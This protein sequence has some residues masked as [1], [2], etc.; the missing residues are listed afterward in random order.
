MDA[1]PAML[2]IGSESPLYT[3]GYGECPVAP[4]ASYN[5]GTCHCEMKPFSDHQLLYMGIQGHLTKTRRVR[6]DQQVW[7]LRQILNDPKLQ[8]EFANT[9]TNRGIL[10][11]ISEDHTPSVATING[12]ICKELITVAEMAVGKVTISGSDRVQ[13][14]TWEVT[15]AYHKMAKKRLAQRKARKTVSPDT[16]LQLA[17]SYKLARAKFNAA[18][19]ASWQKRNRRLQ[20]AI[21][22]PLNPMHCK[23]IHKAFNDI[24][25]SA[26]APR[27]MGTNIT[28]RQSDKV[29]KSAHG[30][31]NV[32][33]LVSEYTESV[34]S[35]ACEAGEFDEV[36]RQNVEDGLAALQ[37][38][39]QFQAS[40]LCNTPPSA[41][42]LHAVLKVASKRLHKSPGKDGVTNWMICWGG[43]DVVH[44]YNRVWDEGSL[45][46]QWNEAEISYLYKGGTKSKSEIT[47]YRPISLIPIIAKLFTRCWLPRLLS[48][49][50]DAIGKEQGCGRKGQGHLEHL[51][52]L[53][54][55]IEDS[56]EG[57]DGQVQKEVYA[58]FADVSK[59]YDQVWRSGLYSLLYVYG[60]R[61]KMWQIIQQ[62]LDNARAT[63]KWSGT[64]G[65][66]VPLAEGLR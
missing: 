51:W 28:W 46:T 3:I 16:T 60:V 45:P 11:A 15:K 17:S 53:M 41:N 61:G 32:G 43:P 42:E 57:R 21:E 40:P 30:A 2:G 64:V 25:G 31:A 8:Q 52:A 34:S 62:W 24:T 10:K 13:S 39:P 18:Y 7:K 59:A 54:E 1:M 5:D 65:P 47:S 66:C 9:V 23:Q 22:D 58:L 29:S 27:A 48:L 12:R 56:C 20:V 26:K 36:F 6:P 35:K 19:K 14:H 63:T 49:T 37:Q 4:T 50:T 38:A 55:L 33:R 44:L